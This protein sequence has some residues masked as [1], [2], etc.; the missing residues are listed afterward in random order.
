MLD[1]SSNVPLYNLLY[2]V[3]GFDSVDDE[4]APELNTVWPENP[5]EWTRD[6]EPP[7]AYWL[8]FLK[9]NLHTLNMLKG[10]K[11]KRRKKERRRE[12]EKK[13]KRLFYYLIPFF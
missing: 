3:S 5:H 8:Y 1:P 11:E 4:S 2:S 6:E 10:K 7:Y 9:A 13:K 12:K